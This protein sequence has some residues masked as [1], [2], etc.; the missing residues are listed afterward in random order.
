MLVMTSQTKVLNSRNLKREFSHHVHLVPISLG[1]NDIYTE[2]TSYIQWIGD[3]PSKN[4]PVRAT[5]RVFNPLFNSNNRDSHPDG[6]LAVVNSKSEEIYSNAMI[7][8]GFDEVKRRAPWPSLEGERD[9]GPEETCPETVRFQG[10]RV[11]YFCLDR[12]SADND[13]ILNRIVNLKE[14]AKKE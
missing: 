11:A 3:C 8:T 1:I 2:S 14:D 10:M 7:E 9:L 13:V 5:V 4:S 12:D 6:F